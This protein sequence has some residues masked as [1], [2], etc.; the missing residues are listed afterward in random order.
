M[1]SDAIHN[2]ADV[3]T[4]AVVFLGFFVSKKAPTT[5]TQI[6]DAFPAVLK[7]YE[8]LWTGGKVLFRS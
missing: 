4:S 3:S 8:D 1:L 2:L 5:V 6:I 7:T